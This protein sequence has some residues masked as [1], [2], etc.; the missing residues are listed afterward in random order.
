MSRR[1]EPVIPDAIL[2]QL[3]VGADAK[4]AFD[5]N[6][7]IDQLKKAL[8]DR[9]LKAELDHHL[10]GDES[11]N[12]RNGYGKKT[13]LT[14]AGAL[15]LSIPRDRQGSFDPQLI[16]AVVG[17]DTGHRDTEACVIGDGGFEE[18][19]CAGGFLVRQDLGEGHA[20]GVIDADV[21][22]LPAEPFAAGPSVAPT[23]AI[24]CDAMS[25]L[26]EA[27]KFFDVEVDHL[28]GMGALI[29][30]NRLR[31]L[32]RLQRIEA[33]SAQDAADSGWADAD[34]ACDLLSGVALT[35]QGL[36]G[37]GRRRRGLAWR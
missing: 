17:H 24:A 10:K 1:R 37:G 27:A 16:A 25:D 33:Q 6:G 15:E 9:A 29:P 2:D 21:D 4:T 34:F 20:R 26:L 19:D 22:E 13:V 12:S 18:R 8:A 3:L 7:L 28:A 31:R 35:A 32:Q 36:D 11:G 14:D 30:A 5:P 23:P